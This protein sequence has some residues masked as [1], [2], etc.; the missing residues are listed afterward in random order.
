MSNDL[1]EKMVRLVVTITV[2]S[3]FV[4]G[5]C[6]VLEMNSIPEGVAALILTLICGMLIYLIVYYWYGK[7][8][9]CPSCNSWFC[10][11]KTGEEVVKRENV[12]VP[13]RNKIRDESGYIIGSLEQYVPGE[14][15]TYRLNMVCKK[16]GKRCY[17]TYKKDIPKI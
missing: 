2:A 1:F 11:K 15:I 13:V 5:I 17:S 3:C 16:C 10:L 14:R 12:S 6:G 8:Y 4:V 7:D 9:K